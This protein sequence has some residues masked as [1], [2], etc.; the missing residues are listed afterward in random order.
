MTQDR[1]FRLLSALA[2]VLLAAPLSPAQ[3]SFQAPVG[4]TG[5]TVTNPTSLQFGPDGRLY[6]SETGGPDHVGGDIHVYEIQRTDV[7]SNGI[8]EYAVTSTEIIDLV[9]LY[10]P[11]HDDDGTPNPTQER[12]I[13]GIL[14]VGTPD[15]PVLYVSS[16]DWRIGA[17]STGG[18]VNL[19]TNSG[20]LHRLT[21]VGTG[22]D[23]PNGYWDKVDLVRGLPRSEENHS[24]N[25]MQLSPDGTTMYLTVGGFT[26]A[27][28]PSNNFTFITE[29][30]YAAV[31]VA[32]DLP[33][34]DAMP[35]QTDASLYSGDGYVYQW[36]YDLP[37]L[38]DPTRAN[39]NGI[40]DP[41]DPGYLNGFTE[42]N[43]PFGGNDGLNQAKI[44]PVNHPGNP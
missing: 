8:G 18:D 35:L 1:A 7:D 26:N 44:D 32:I 20:I 4:L 28:A 2:L 11:N 6:V 3:V 31:V 42:A 40:T 16:S 25:G 27:G 15:N 24:V 12:Q 10:T 21:W 41:S 23:D 14:V 13:T 33:A 43:D 29:Y 39:V 38:D 34:L 17:G 19:D 37:T 9:K 36:V 5:E 30:A 22:R